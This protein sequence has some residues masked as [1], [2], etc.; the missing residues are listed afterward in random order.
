MGQGV[1]DASLFIHGEPEGDRV[2]LFLDS[3]GSFPV[4]RELE[5]VDW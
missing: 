5:A 2:D 3:V 1:D 4:C